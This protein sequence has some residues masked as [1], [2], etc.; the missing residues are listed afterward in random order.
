MQVLP[1]IVLVFSNGHG[2]VSGIEFAR[3]PRWSRE[4]R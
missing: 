2:V 1:V 4:A 3:L